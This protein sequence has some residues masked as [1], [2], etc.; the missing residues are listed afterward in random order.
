VSLSVTVVNCCATDAGSLDTAAISVC[1]PKTVGIIHFGNQNLEPNDTIRFVL[2]SNPAD[3]LGSVVQYSDS[4]YFPFLQGVMSFDSTYYAAVIA[5]NL[6]AND[7]IDAADPCFSLRLGPKIRWHKIPTIAVGSPPDSV[8]GIG[9]ANVQFDFAGAP[10]FEFT[11]EIS[12]NG[13]VLFARTESVDGFQLVVTVC[14]EDF[15]LP[16]D[17]GYFNFQVNYFVDKFCGCAD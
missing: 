7:S 3:P 14:P 15:D 17:D 4:L 6:L 13:Q 8:C 9:C 10:P 12:Q 16:A 11:W 5:G 2:F 1:G